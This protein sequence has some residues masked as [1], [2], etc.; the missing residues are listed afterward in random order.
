MRKI[1]VT[2]TAAVFSLTAWASTPTG[3]KME[4]DTKK[5]K[6]EWV[7]EKVTGKHFGTVDIK[8]G[9]FEVDGNKITGGEVHVDMNTINVQDLKGEDKQKLEGHLKSDDF[10]SAEKHQI[11]KFVIKSP[12]KEKGLKDGNTHTLK[13]DLSIKGKTESV[14]FPARITMENGKLNAYAS[15]KLDRTRWGIRY[16]SGSFFDDLGDKTIYDEFQVKFNVEASK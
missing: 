8:K 16:G 4:I 3:D 9:H 7:G 15:F 1:A 12:K 13:G 10:F 2:L 11:V 6:L 14:S 5:S